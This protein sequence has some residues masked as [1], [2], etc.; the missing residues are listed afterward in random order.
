MKRDRPPL[1]VATKYNYRQMLVGRRETESDLNVLSAANEHL[2]EELDAARRRTGGAWTD[3]KTIRVKVTD[4]VLEPEDNTIIEVNVL[5]GQVVGV[6]LL[7]RGVYPHALQ[8]GPFLLWGGEE[9]LLWFC[10]ESE[11]AEGVHVFRQVWVK[12]K[13]A[14]T[15]AG[16]D[17][18]MEAFK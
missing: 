5:R 1:P 12:N 8:S 13:W 16:I 14:G 9:M 17:F 2:W 11:P 18:L 3:V 7:Q 15:H 10:E 4:N 6:R